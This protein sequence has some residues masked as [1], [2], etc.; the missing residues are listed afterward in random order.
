M[1]LPTFMTQVIILEGIK[2]PFSYEYNWIEQSVNI[3]VS[4]INEVFKKIE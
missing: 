2:D 4:T 3:V 1:M